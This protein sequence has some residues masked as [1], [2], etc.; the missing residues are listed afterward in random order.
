M[1]V[2]KATARFTGRVSRGIGRTCLN[3]SAWLSLPFFKAQTS[4]VVSLIKSFLKPKR[5]DVGETFDQS[6]VRQGITEKALAVRV[7]RIRF[8]CGL[9]LFFA[10]AVFVYTLYLLF[11]GVFFAIILTILVGIL[12]L[13]KA[14][15]MHFWLY[16]IKR[17]KLGC[18][19]SD[20]LSNKLPVEERK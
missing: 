10:V 17:R 9:Y 14:A 12:F 2:F 7:Q 15:G 20:W 3:V 13:L 18:S 4:G 8:Q 16:Q 6:M 11:H 1:G 19:L 5:A